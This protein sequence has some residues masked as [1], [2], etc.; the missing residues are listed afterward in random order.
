MWCPFN[1]HQT[2]LD[3]LAQQCIKGA[4]GLFPWNQI[5]IGPVNHEGRCLVIPT[6]NLC[7]RTT[8]NNL[9]QGRLWKSIPVLHRRSRA[10]LLTGETTND[11]GQCLSL[12]IDVEDDA[13]AWIDAYTRVR[14]RLPCTDNSVI[15][16]LFDLLGQGNL[17]WDLGT[18]GLVLNRFQYIILGSRI[19]CAVWLNGMSPPL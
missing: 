8:G 13:A 5:V 18:Y 14:Q 15:G 9:L 1:Q 16:D 2:S 10:L 3:S 6:D 19:F 17:T 11:D 7:E 4:L 12:P